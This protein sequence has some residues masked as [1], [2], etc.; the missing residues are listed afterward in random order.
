MAYDEAQLQEATKILHQKE[1]ELEA[2][3][4][5]IFARV[6]ASRSNIPT[7]SPPPYEDQP[8]HSPGGDNDNADDFSAEG[9]SAPSREPDIGQQSLVSSMLYETEVMWGSE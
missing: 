7:D 8:P 2:L 6:V 5:R 3:R 1:G 9:D 4:G